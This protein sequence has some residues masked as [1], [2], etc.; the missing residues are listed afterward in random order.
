MVFFLGSLNLVC[1]L[2]T[3]WPGIGDCGLSQIRG[4]PLW[5]LVSCFTTPRPLAPPTTMLLVTLFSDPL[6]VVFQQFTHLDQNLTSRFHPYSAT[7]ILLTMCSL[8]CLLITHAF[9][10]CFY[11][12]S[13]FG[14]LAVLS[15]MRAMVWNKTSWIEMKENIIGGKD[16]HICYIENPPILIC[17]IHSVATA[18]YNSD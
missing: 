18:K 8:K 11:E 1:Q 15:S 6:S 7:Q 2:T 16:C 12:V 9:S 17:A 13:P 4:E 14:Q 10:H 3:G 5:C